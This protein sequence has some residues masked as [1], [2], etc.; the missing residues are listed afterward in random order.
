V[1]LVLP[2]GVLLV[3]LSI[4]A[5]TYAIFGAVD[6]CHG[7]A[8]EPPVYVATPPSSIPVAPRVRRRPGK[9]RA[10]PVRKATP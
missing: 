6:A 3:A 4:G 7:A 10:R 1:T 8:L 9:R 5:Q 2:L